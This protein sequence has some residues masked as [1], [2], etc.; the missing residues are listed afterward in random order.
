MLTNSFDGTSCLLELERTDGDV[1]RFDKNRGNRFVFC[2]VDSLADAIFLTDPMLMID[3]S[4]DWII[5]FVELMM[6]R[7]SCKIMFEL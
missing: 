1:V 7:I 5:C 6:F 3:A 2:K 4:A